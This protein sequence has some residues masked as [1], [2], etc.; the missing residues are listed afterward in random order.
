MKEADAIAIERLRGL[1]ER[2]FAASVMPR[3]SDRFW[4]EYAAISAQAP[5]AVGTVVGTDSRYYV[6]VVDRLDAD[7][8][9]PSTAGAIG[10]IVDALRDDIEHGYLRRH[11]EL[12]AGEIFTDFLDMAKSLVDNGYHVPAASLTGAVLEDGLRRLARSNGLPVRPRDDISSLNNRLAQR[13]IYSN[14]VRQKIQVWSTIRNHADH[15]EFSDVLAPD[16]LDMLAGAT[17]S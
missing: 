14:L 9:Y 10:A 17:A 1:A 3:E 16:V 13:G 5:V 4:Q 6:E 15:G 11:S 2:C 12:I 7:Q 8:P